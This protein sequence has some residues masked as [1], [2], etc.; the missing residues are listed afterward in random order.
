MLTSVTSRIEMVPSVLALQRAEMKAFLKGSMQSL[1][2][3]FESQLEPELCSWKEPLL[4]NL[5]EMMF[6]FYRAAAA[7]EDLCLESTEDFHWITHIFFPILPL[8]TGQLPIQ[9]FAFVLCNIP[10]KSGQICT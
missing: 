4:S 7:A 1:K 2:S 6:N 3:M 10:F 8:L 5:P 9:D